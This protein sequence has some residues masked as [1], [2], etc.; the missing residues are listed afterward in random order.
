MLNSFQSILLINNKSNRMI[1]SCSC[2]KEHFDRLHAQ[3]PPLLTDLFH[4]VISKNLGHKMA[5]FLRYPFSNNLVCPFSMVQKMLL[6]F[7]NLLKPN[8]EF[9]LEFNNSE[10]S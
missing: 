10:L 6:M 8:V 9:N 3:L 7:L 5:L 4:E 1:N 2:V